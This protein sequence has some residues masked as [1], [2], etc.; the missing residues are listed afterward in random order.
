[1]IHARSSARRFG[2]DPSAYLPIHDFM[3]SSKAACGDN[4]HRALTHTSW[5][6]STVLERV[7]G[8]EITVT[9]ADGRTRKV[10]VRD[11]GEQHVLED[12]G[13]FIPTPQDFLSE[14]FLKTWMMFG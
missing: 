13:G 2:G 12:F 14:M 1:M 7:F 6:I 3:D 9:L 11:I 5:F 4:R 10:S 8:H